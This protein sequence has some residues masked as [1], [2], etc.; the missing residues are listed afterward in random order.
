[1]SL[2]QAFLDELRARTPLAALIGRSLKLQRAGREYKALCPFHDEKTP[3]FT[4]VE[5]KGFWHCHGCGA[6]GDAIRWLMERQGL[7]FIDAVREL[8]E[9]AG[10]EMPAR[11]P[12]AAARAA[13]IDGIRPAI[14]AAQ[15]LFVR[16]LSDPSAGSGQAHSTGSGQAAA[17]REYLATRGIGADAITRFGLGWAPARHG[18]VKALGIG[19]E[20]ALAAGLVWRATESAPGEA[21]KWGE[22]FRDRITFPVHDHRGRIVGFSG[23]AMQPSGTVPKYKNSPDSEIFDKGATLYNLHRAADAAHAAKRLIIV[24]GQMD[25]IALDR[26]G[27]AEAVAPMGTAL[28]PRQIERAWRIAA[29]P[30]LAFDGDAAG[31]KAAVRACTMAL[32]GIGPG[33][34]IAVALFPDGSDPDDVV[35]G[36]GSAEA[37]RS[38]IEAVLVEAVP[39]WRIL[40]DAAAEGHDPA[41]P[42]SVAG[43]WTAL[44]ALARTIEHEEARAQYLAAWRAR[45]E[46]E[47]SLVGATVQTL[48]AL[49][50]AIEAEEGG[51]AWPEEQDESERR[52][53]M[54]VRRALELRRQRA[55]INDVLRDLSA[56]A[57][58]AGYAP[59]AINAAVRD[60]EAA[61]DGREDFE[62]IYALYRRVL[63]IRG[64]MTEAMMPPPADARGPRVVNAMQKRLSRTM[65]MIEARGIEADGAAH[66]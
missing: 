20:T 6:H 7:D 47:I 66:G 57:K 13:R 37:A 60:I 4:V 35:R 53:I 49:H 14:E 28:T 33:R 12:E 65:V 58:A 62:A 23:R 54:I 29:R 11:S 59:K 32:P 19:F 43:V 36:A 3:S 22:T 15:A 39:I 46:R 63:G 61:A 64:P 8:A 16:E 44:D 1:M 24:E 21:R 51:Y 50:A 10:M 48:P 2:P 27:I 31:R 5:E 30:I 25:V 40:F 42:E 56:M 34:S 26:A 45:F 17:A 41:D 55:E 52:L 18:Y 38:A 9:A